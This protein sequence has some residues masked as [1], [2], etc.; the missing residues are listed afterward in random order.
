MIMIVVVVVENAVDGRLVCK[1]VVDFRGGVA[2]QKFV[3]VAIE[4]RV[5]QRSVPR[6]GSHGVQSNVKEYEIM[7]YEY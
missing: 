2:K 1:P 3:R 4:V 5:K 6:S 7:I